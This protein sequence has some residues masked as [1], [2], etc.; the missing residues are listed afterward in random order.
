MSDASAGTPRSVVIVGAG[1]AGYTLA[2]ELKKSAPSARVTIVTEDGGGFYSKP[3]LSNA[4]A[5]GKSAQSLESHSAERMAEQTGARVITGA[6]A[7]E[8]RRDRRALLTSQGELPYDMLALATGAAPIRLALSGDAADQALSVNHLSDFKEFE[9][10]L[11]RAKERRGGAP[12]RVAIMGAGLIGC[13]FADDLLAWG[14][15]PTV[16]D[17]SALPLS[18]LCAPGLSRGLK[19][20]LEAKGALFK[21]SDSVKAVWRARP[22]KEGLDPGG[23]WLELANG[24]RL[25][26]DLLLSAVGL[27]PRVELASQAGL[28]VERGVLVDAYGFSSDERVMALGD[29]AQYWQEGGPSRVAPY[30]A[31]LMSAAK[32]M[33][34]T[35]GGERSKIEW[36]HAAIMVKTPSYP[37]ALRPPEPG[38][39]GQWEQS[40]QEGPLVWRF[41]S[42]G[43]MRGYALASR[44]AGERKRLEAQLAAAR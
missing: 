26:C 14:A 42:E 41:I 3:G 27:R 1:L 31:P 37:L 16:I 21:L 18:A 10:R 30:V 33:A 36:P 25:E 7:L 23:L 15:R 29:C 34:K 17:P 2:K 28:A 39:V 12:A 32:A 44:D 6:Q 22:L 35:I 4:L 40:E 11:N 8:I 5:T 24:E 38:A 13:E 43:R 20:A 9:A 19:E